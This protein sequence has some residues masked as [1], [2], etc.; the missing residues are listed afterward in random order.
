MSG[1]TELTV[2]SGASEIN[3]IAESYRALIGAED[4]SRFLDSRPGTPFSF[5]PGKEVLTIRHKRRSGDLRRDSQTFEHLAD[6]ESPQSS[7]ASDGTLVAFDEE[8][9]YFKPMSP[10]SHK[11]GYESPAAIIPSPTPNNIGLKI[12]VDLLAKDLASAVTKHG[13]LEDP[14]ESAALQIWTMIEAY[15]KLRDRV[16]DMGLKYD[17]VLS[18]H[19]SIETWLGGLYVAHERLTGTDTGRQH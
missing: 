3:H 10:L 5:F 17:E 11:L 13:Q 18:L 15:E 4:P 1:M 19:Q 16:M 12:C 7:P 6:D 9:I 14:P 2:T 8:T